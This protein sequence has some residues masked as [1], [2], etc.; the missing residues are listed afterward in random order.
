MRWIVGDIHGCASALGRLL[1][2][3][4]YDPSRD[5]LWSVGDLVNTGTESLAALRLWIGTGARGV[6][7]NHDIHALRVYA[8]KRSVRPEDT[9]GELLAA[10]DAGELLAALKSLPLLAHLPGDDGA[11]GV[12]IV[13]AG[14]HPSWR[15]L[16]ATAR[17]VNA[18]P[19]DDA[20]FKSPES[21]FATRVRCC[22][23][24]GEMLDDPGPP[25]ECPAPY[26]PWD[27]L[28]AGD[29]FVIHGHWGKRGHYRR[30]RTMS[31]DSGCVYG[32][33]LTAWCQED[34][35]IVQV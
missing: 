30:R 13:H 32:G 5:E 3:I 31:L 10:P 24:D 14:L 12:W 23:P 1:E 27:S 9:L 6:L 16:H 11:A 15:D 25:G 35:R 8:G 21:R 33:P 22:T 18:G 19:R 29:A 17:R 4:R 28:Y 7:G 2:T 26:R 34:D 20:W